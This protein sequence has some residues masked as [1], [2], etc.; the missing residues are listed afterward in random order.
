MTDQPSPAPSG[1]A[2]SL[3][4]AP[5]EAIQGKAKPEKQPAI[6]PLTEPPA[7]L[8]GMALRKSFD[9]EIEAELEAAM[10]G[11]D[12]QSLMGDVNQART[13]PA[14]A[15]TPAD[16]GR[17]KGR[18]I[19]I[20]GDD[21]FVDVGGRS[22]GVLSL[23]Q[24]SEPPQ[25]GQDVDVHIEGYDHANGLLVL[26]R[27]GAA[28]AHV[29]WSSVAEGMIV[30]AKVTGHNKGGLQ[31]E[32][33][34]IRGFIPISQIDLMRVEDLQPF[35]NQ[36]L[37]CIVT[38]AVPSERN[39]V[40]SR[41]ALLEQERDSVKA[42]LWTELAEGQIRSGVVRKVLDFGAF[43]DLGGVDGLLPISEFS[44]QRVNN[45]DEHLKMG[46]RLDVEVLR[47]D[48]EHQK[49]TLSRKH[50]EASPWDDIESQFP[51]G[52][53]VMGKVTR[54]MDFGAFVE[55]NP[56]LEGLVHISEL[57]TKRVHR[58]SDIVKPDQ[59]VLVQII[60]IEPEQRRIGLSIKAI[61]KAAEEKALAEAEAKAEA[62]E[63]ALPAKPPVPRRT[64]LK[65]GLGQGNP[66]A[67]LL[68]PKPD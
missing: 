51:V 24:F 29:D 56:G 4:K 8:A 67:G 49:I 63:A 48:R 55:I 32:V 20:H 39:L 47:L 58:A 41:R 50:L 21:V 10:S 66:F 17:K 46:Q 35:V 33:N 42:K 26:S 9:A 23:D 2:A 6:P 37:T 64:D 18:I 68:K 7:K 30:E 22:Q 36:R 53:Q 28:V 27:Q 43:I 14:S 31:V 11:L 60:K 12:K 61:A 16:S 19:S 44:W 65:G 62:E 1:E 52:T 15:A 57:S 3:P 25:I 40:L 59:Q 5:K 45:L 13:K 34:G 38:E 54:I